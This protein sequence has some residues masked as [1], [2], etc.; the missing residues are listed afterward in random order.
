MG[1]W[2][3]KFASWASDV[4]GNAWSFIIAVIVILTWAV[5]GP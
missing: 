4:M 1:T 5:T 2:F 3:M